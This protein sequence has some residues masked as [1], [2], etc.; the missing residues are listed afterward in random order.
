MGCLV[1]GMETPNWKSLPEK[2]TEPQPIVSP[3]ELSRG[4]L[5][6]VVGPDASGKS[7]FVNALAAKIAKSR[8]V[9]QCH[10]GLPPG[11]RW[12][13]VCRWILRASRKGFALLSGHRS[14]VG[15]GATYPHFEAAF[16]VLRAVDRLQLSARCRKQADAGVIVITDRYPGR[17][18]GSANGPRAKP[19]AGWALAVLRRVEVRI[20]ERV[21]SPDVIIRLS[22]PVDEAIRRNASRDVPKSEERI[23]ESRRESEAVEFAGVP[24]IELVSTGGV[25]VHVRYVLGRLSGIFEQGS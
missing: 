24:E 23:I 19:R 3:T 8:E 15:R 14:A 12:T 2:M 21:P 17:M 4:I 11:Q 18:V 6:A 20:Y 22:V 25:E 9:V 13:G 10:F 1:P 16:D 5:V 7:T